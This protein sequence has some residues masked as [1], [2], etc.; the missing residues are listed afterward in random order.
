MG[1]ACCAP[2]L[3]LDQH[4]N[5]YLTVGLASPN[6]PRATI[7]LPSP[8]YGQSKYMSK[9]PIEKVIS[10]DVGIDITMPTITAPSIEAP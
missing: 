7:P 8:S 3:P 9:G 5:P 1:N 2:E 10:K 6:N 4:Y